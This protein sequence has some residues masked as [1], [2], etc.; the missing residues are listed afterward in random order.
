MSVKPDVK[1]ESYKKVS[2][3]GFTDSR[4]KEKKDYRRHRISVNIPRN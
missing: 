2:G 4:Q 3:V 1:W